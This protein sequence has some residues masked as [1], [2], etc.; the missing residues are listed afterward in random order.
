M[1]VLPMKKLDFL[2]FLTIGTALLKTT[3]KSFGSVTFVWQGVN[4]LQY[5]L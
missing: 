1:L 5:S 3:A 2:T 4:L